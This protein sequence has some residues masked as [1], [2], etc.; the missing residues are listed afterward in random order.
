MKLR[1]PVPMGSYSAWSKEPIHTSNLVGY[2]QKSVTKPLKVRPGNPAICHHTWLSAGPICRPGHLRGH[3]GGSIGPC[4]FRTGLSL[5]IAVI[6]QKMWPKD[7][8]SCHSAHSPQPAQPSLHPAGQPVPSVDTADCPCAIGKASCCTQKLADTPSPASAH[9][10]G[11]PGLPG[12][13][14]PV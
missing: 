8:F 9:F 13:P 10:T 5:L 2:P 12:V 4:E 1:P 6:Q 11:P 14:Q 7:Q 3:Q